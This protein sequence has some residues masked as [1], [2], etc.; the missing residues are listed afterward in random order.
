MIGLCLFRRWRWS[1]PLSLLVSIGYLWIARH[2]FQVAIDFALGQVG[3]YGVPE[4]QLRPAWLAN[5]FP[6]FIMDFV[7][8]MA[9]ANL[10]TLM[11]AGRVPRISTIL[12]RHDVSATLS[13]LGVIIVASALYL[14][15]SNRWPDL[16]YYTDHLV[17]AVGTILMIVGSLSARTWSHR[18]LSLRPLRWLGTIGYSVFLWHMPIIYVVN[19]YPF[20]E[21]KSPQWRFIEVT[22]RVVPLTLLIS[23]VYYRLVEKP[24]MSSKTSQSVAEIPALAEPTSGT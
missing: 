13:V 2:S 19:G 23:I 10:A 22:A 3:K 5:Q 18:F 7:L 20:L 9:A 8:G 14:N 1:I 17:T 6:T 12:S 16:A 24:F 21:G 15:G 4:N 11:N